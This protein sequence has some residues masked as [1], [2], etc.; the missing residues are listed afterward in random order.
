[1]RPK[2]SAEVLEARRRW[3]VSLLQKGLRGAEVARLIGCSPCSVT[4]WKEVV[5]KSGVEGLA[6]K[7]HPGPRPRLSAKQKER[8]LELLKERPQ[9]HGYP[10]ELWTLPRV[11]EVIERHFGVHYHPAHVW[12]MLRALGWS[13]QK[14]ERRARERNEEKIARW[15][16]EK[17]PHIKKRARRGA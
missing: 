3:A 10:N 7:P 5:E 16:K 11:A 17:W 14:P 6:A 4:S 2:G 8:V 15:R 13:C 9:V 12:R 1:M